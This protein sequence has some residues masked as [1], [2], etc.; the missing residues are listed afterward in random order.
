MQSCH[1]IQT[2]QS[3]HPRPA[4]RRTKRRPRK[5]RHPRQRHS[6]ATPR[7]PRPHTR[8]RS[9]RA[10][11]RTPRR[12]SHSVQTHRAPRP[13]LLRVPG[14]GHPRAGPRSPSREGEAQR[15]CRNGR[16][17][18]SRERSERARTRNWPNRKRRARSRNPLARFQN[19]AAHAGA[20][21]AFPLAISSSTQAARNREN[22]SKGT[23]DCSQQP[24]L[25]EIERAQAVGDSRK[26]A[27]KN[28]GPI[29]LGRRTAE[30]AVPTLVHLS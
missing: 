28:C 8:A 25:S 1:L 13:P 15:K 21:R 11:V 14:R 22:T 5:V 24:A 17:R 29:H 18:P 16:L 26:E 7:I 20:K 4:R 12:I 9:H 3:H 19:L 6:H 30:A 23:Q 27:A 2:R 10:P